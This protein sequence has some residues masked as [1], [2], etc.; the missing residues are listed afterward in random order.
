MAGSIAAA[1]ARFKASGSPSLTGRP[2]EVTIGSQP[3]LREIVMGD[4]RERNT[5]ILR[6]EDLGR[7]LPVPR[8]PPLPGDASETAPTN[9]GIDY[10]Q[11]PHYP[12]AGPDLPP[13]R[14]TDFLWHWA[15]IFAGT[16]LAGIVVGVLGL[17][18]GLVIGIKLL[19]QGADLL[20]TWRAL[21]TVTLTGLGIGAAF[22]LWIDY[23]RAVN[24]HIRGD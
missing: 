15:D 7:Q 6:A 11:L 10:S 13:R 18:S 16:L 23:R 9:Q 12:R 3:S 8:Q 24:S 2:Y 1:G 4:H 20:E 19:V 14:K 21:G 22:G 17:L 5:D